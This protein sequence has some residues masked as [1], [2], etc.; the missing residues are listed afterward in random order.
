MLCNLTQYV[1]LCSNAQVAAQVDVQVYSH[2]LHV[3]ESNIATTPQFRTSTTLMSLSI[4]NVKCWI[5]H[6]F[7][8]RNVHT[9][10]REIGENV[11]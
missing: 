6:G 1:K 2:V 10:F 3:S 7:Q 8:G 9:K 5:W 11:P 4:Q